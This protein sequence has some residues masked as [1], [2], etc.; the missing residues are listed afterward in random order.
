MII[1]D[2]SSDS[3]ALTGGWSK[4]AGTITYGGQTFET[5]KNGDA[6]VKVSVDENNATITSI[7]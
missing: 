6:T 3:V 4:E 1:A 5:F 2:D 7:A